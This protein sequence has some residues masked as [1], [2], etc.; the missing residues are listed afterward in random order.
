MGSGQSAAEVG[1]F[2]IFKVNPGSPAFEAGLEVF[3]DFIVEI[4]GCK[5]DSD[6]KLFFRKI[7]E[8]ENTRTKLVIYNIRT[9]KSREVFVMPRKWGGAGLL[10]AVVRFDALDNVDNQGMRILEVFPNSPAMQAGL[11][12]YKDY[13]LGTTEVMFRDMDELVEIVNLCLGKSMQ[14][15]VYNSS[16]ESIREVTIMPNNG[17]GGDGSIGADIRT[18]LLHRIPAPRR[19]L[20]AARAQPHVLQPALY[21]APVASAEAPEAAASAAT[22]M[23]PASP[24]AAVP[25][26]VQ[27]PAVGALEP[28]A[29]EGAAPVGA[30]TAAEPRSPAAAAGPP[31]AHRAAEAP[32]PESPPSPPEQRAGVQPYGSGGACLPAAAP[33]AAVPAEEGAGAAAAH[34]ASA[35][36]AG[37]GTA[38]LMSPLR[39]VAAPVAEPGTPATMAPP[40]VPP[41]T[42]IGVMEV[43]QG[44]AP[45]MVSPSIVHIPPDV[46]TRPGGVPDSPLVARPL[47]VSSPGPDVPGVTPET[48]PTAP[49]VI[50]ESPVQQPASGLL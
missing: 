48:P 12:P 18:G 3:F 36:L 23:V 21:P 44:D 22:L 50:F 1:G 29:A 13:L 45:N 49:G 40:K 27:L 39:S 10:G 19:G 16:T 42:P 15:Y 26:A 9:H 24:P 4:G 28:A 2:R 33:A 6:Q 47:G 11:I 31:E 35:V 32:P 30:A 20:A 14:V 38:E 37:L 25:P 46:Q 43:A 17:W 41:S 8:A 5:M 34:E 7:Q